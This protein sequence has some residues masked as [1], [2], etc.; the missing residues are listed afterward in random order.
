MSVLFRFAMHHEYIPAAEN[1]MRL[2][3]M[4]TARKKEP[5][6]LTRKEFKLLVEKMP[7]GIFRTMV[8]VCGCL[9]LRAS[10]VAGLRWEDIDWLKRE[11]HI[12]NG[13]VNGRIGD[14]KT[15]ASRRKLPLS[16]SLFREL[17][18]RRK[19][20]EFKEFDDFI[21]A[22]PYS[23][24][25]RPYDP[26]EVRKKYIDAAATAACLGQGIGWHTLR[27]SYRRWI[28]EKDHPLELQRDLMRHSQM[29]TTMDI[30]GGSSFPEKLREASEELVEDLLQ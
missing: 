18:A 22:S 23:A 9:G 20:S 8:I 15:K 11:I 2:F 29:S 4:S 13:V 7:V 12:R 16:P 17:E 26:G 24:G 28:G 30:Y 25:E 10:E 21:F 1:P 19:Y 3:P 14:V 5:R 6:I 27:H